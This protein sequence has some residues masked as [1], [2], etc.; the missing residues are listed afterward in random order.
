M[1]WLQD[2]NR[3]N[4]DNLHNRKREARKHYRNKK[5]EHLKAKIGEI[6][7]RPAN[8][9]TCTGLSMALRRGEILELI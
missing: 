1:Q 6:P 2:P 5:K 3:S 7:R 4:V 8:A 9:E